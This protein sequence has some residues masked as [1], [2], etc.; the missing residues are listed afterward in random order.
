MSP[1]HAGA[2][3]PDARVGVW[4]SSGRH[5]AITVS[6]GDFTPKF[7]QIVT[8]DGSDLER[9]APVSGTSLFGFAPTRASFVI[10]ESSLLKVYDADQPELPPR[11][12]PAPYGRLEPQ[13]FSPDG[14]YFVFTARDE[15]PEPGL[16]RLDLDTMPPTLEPPFTEVGVRP[17]SSPDSRFLS[18]VRYV[19]GVNEL[20]LADWTND[21]VRLR[22]VGAALNN[23]NSA[24]DAQGRWLDERR[25]LW[26]D[27]NRRVHLTTLEDDELYGRGPAHGP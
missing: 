10:L 26:E 19:N 17:R 22:Q 5:L 14:R 2:V 13:Y 6:E 21:E 7:T 12:A 9:S 8:V 4:S 24:L 1:V 25:L 11:N 18:F 20:W 16:R 15:A 3:D 23:V 27:L